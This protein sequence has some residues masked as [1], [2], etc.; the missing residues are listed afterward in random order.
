[1]AFIICLFISADPLQFWLLN[2]ISS[3]TVSIVENLWILELCISPIL[4]RVC[5]ASP[6]SAAAVDRGHQRA[7]G[8]APQPEASRP[9]DQE[10]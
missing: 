5:S 9:G 2:I 10:S 3:S 1:M 6:S 8:P 4:C 7:E